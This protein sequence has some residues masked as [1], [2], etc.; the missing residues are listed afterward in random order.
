MN[1]PNTAPSGNFAAPVPPSMA[2]LAEMKVAFK[3]VDADNDGKVRGI[4][5]NFFCF[6]LVFLGY[7]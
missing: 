5:G 7:V 1:R 3:G 6:N 2:Q 4:D